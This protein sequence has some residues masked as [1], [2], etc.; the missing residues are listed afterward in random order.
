M[1]GSWP[2][3]PW[4]ML[5]PTQYQLPVAHTHTHT[6]VTTAQGKGALGHKGRGS[7][8]SGGGVRAHVSEWLWSCPSLGLT[9]SSSLSWG[10]EGGAGSLRIPSLTSKAVVPT[11]EVPSPAPAPLPSV[12]TAVAA[13]ATR[14]PG[15]PGRPQE[16]SP[17][18]A[19]GRGGGGRAAGESGLWLLRPVIQFTVQTHT[20]S[21]G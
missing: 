6:Q 9:C 19:W 13:P 14:A 1:G 15:C 11:R 10:A 5:C 20:L 7:R 18:T 16:R 12:P 3:N 8:S 17:R 4:A 21:I 2:T